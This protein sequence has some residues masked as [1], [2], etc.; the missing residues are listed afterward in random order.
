MEEQT[1]DASYDT[2]HHFISESTWDGQGVMGQVAREVQATLAALPGEQG[3]LLDEC[4]WA[5]A[6]SQSVGVGRQYI[7]AL[8]KTDNGQVGVFAALVRG[9]CAGLVG[10]RL[11]LPMAWCTDT[12]RCQQARIPLADQA[13]QSKTE[14]A[15]ALVEQL[16]G[17]GSV[18]ADWVGGDAL[19]GGSPGLRRALQARG[20]AYVL[21]IQPTLHVYTADPTPV[22]AAVWSGRGRR[23]KRRQ[24]VGV[25]QAIQAV[26]AAAGASDTWPVY[27]HRV[28]TKG[29]LRRR[30][31]LVPVWL[32]QADEQTAQAVELLV[33]SELDGSEIK[34]SLCYTPPGAPALSV[35][36][37][38]QRQMQRYW[39]ER[40]FQEAK[41]QL[42]L[43]QAQTRSWPA[44]YHHV[45]LT[46]MAM[47]FMLEAQLE[48]DPDIPYLSFASIK[49]LLARKLRNKLDQDDELQAAIIKRAR[50]VQRPASRPN[51]PT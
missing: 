42:G 44:W 7:G 25:A 13:Y 36:T 17:S 47:H 10:A 32:W 18:T 40:T 24:P 43:H 45:A 35:L 16:L 41:Q 9:K 50:Y 38:L 19:Y 29:P 23:P 5:K 8:G 34:Y 14:Q 2:L 27:A 11:S 51:A 1:P 37:A 15:T 4:G 22:A 28:G 46:L 6:G 12:A 49:L 48:G 26:V 20:Q 3:L 39:I 30:A 21:D 33:S 31:L